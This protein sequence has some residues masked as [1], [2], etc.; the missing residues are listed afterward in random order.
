M[1]YYPIYIDLNGKPAHMIGGGPIAERK[2]ET[3][4]EAG[5]VVT[6]I[7]PHVTDA[8]RRMADEG[9]IQWIQRE[10]RD[11]DLCGAFCT[12]AA[13]NDNAVNTAI[14]EEAT[15]NSQLCNVVD[16]PPLCNFIVPSIVRRG[17]L[18]IAISTSGNSPALARKLR[19]DLTEHIGPEWQALNDL[20]GR[21]RPELKRRYV[22]EAPR[23]DV[24]ARMLDA[25]VLDLLREGRPEDAEALAWTCM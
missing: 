18:S 25:G 16:V 7:A 3:L 5:A 13:T 15:R 14:Y 11:G 4:M 9:R 10:Y 17:D 2:I 12:Y 24:L 21:M 23:N 8:I 22:E 6:V 20:L 1:R 19:M